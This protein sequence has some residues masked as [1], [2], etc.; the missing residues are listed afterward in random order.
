MVFAIFF[1]AVR[2]IGSLVVNCQNASSVAQMV[3]NRG[4]TLA[5]D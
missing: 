5:M 1:G 3:R 2:L 4:M